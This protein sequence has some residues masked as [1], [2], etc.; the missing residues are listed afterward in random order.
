M[1]LRKV[2]RLVSL[3]FIYPIESLIYWRALYRCYKKFGVMPKSQFVYQEIITT[4]TSKRPVLKYIETLHRKLKVEGSF[5]D[6]LAQLTLYRELNARTN[7]AIDKIKD[8]VD[9]K[10][11]I[12]VS[13]FGEER[14]EK[15]TH[16]D[17]PIVFFAT[18]F[19]CDRLAQLLSLRVPKVVSISL[20]VDGKFNNTEFIGLTNPEKRV[21]S[22]ALFLK[23][24]KA[25]AHGVFYIDVGHSVS[26]VEVR[27]LEWTRVMPAGITKII[28]M[29]PISLIPTIAILD[30]QFSSRV[31]VHFGNPIF[32]HD[33]TAQMNDQQIV[34]TLVDALEDFSLEVREQ[35]PESN[36]QFHPYRL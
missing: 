2:L 21:L 5:L 25:G 19:G 22:S 13:F 20:N 34:Q 31:T 11:L 8:G 24:I 35:F 28:R 14:W 15:I 16:L 33:Q 4:L 6:F 29:Q 3:L 26:E 18:H 10:S 32:L 9:L 27:F 23:S 12:E 1:R 36:Y 17:R 7:T 30:R